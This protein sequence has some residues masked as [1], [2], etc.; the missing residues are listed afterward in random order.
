MQCLF[1]FARFCVVLPSQSLPHIVTPC[2]LQSQ[3]WSQGEDGLYFGAVSCNIVNATAAL[4]ANASAPVTPVDL[5]GAVDT[6]HFG[7]ALQSPDLTA[8]W[9]FQVLLGRDF[10]SWQEYHDAVAA[11]P[12]L[13]LGARGGRC[14]FAKDVLRSAEFN[15]SACARDMGCISSRLATL[16]CL[17]RA[18]CTADALERVAASPPP[19]RTTLRLGDASKESL[20]ASVTAMVDGFCDAADSHSVFGN[21]ALMDPAWC[22]GC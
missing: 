21:A 9:S 16:L 19:P 20:P 14:D 17:D 7:Q 5:L 3:C 13:V 8:V 2:I 10:R 6:A 18:R 11:L 12:P 1:L 22:L 15:A 4:F